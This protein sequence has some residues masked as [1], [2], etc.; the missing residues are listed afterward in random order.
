M[1]WRIKIETQRMHALSTQSTEGTGHEERI[2]TRNNRDDYGKIAMIKSLL[3]LLGKASCEPSAKKSAPP[4]SRRP[5]NPAG[6]FRA[7]SIASSGARCAAAKQSAD[8]R[9]LMREAP[10]LPL[11][12]CTMQAGC[13]CRFRKVSDRR[14]GDR[15]LFGG[16]GTNRWYTGNESRQRQGRRSTR[17]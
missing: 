14:D 3:S 4:V 11:A 16:T 2:A 5:P 7:V 9:Y 15:R 10:R 12:A 13:T 17:I 1:E 8:T 6:D